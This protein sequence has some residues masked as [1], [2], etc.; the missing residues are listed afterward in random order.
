MVVRVF[1]TCFLALLL[2]LQVTAW[3]AFLQ[4]KE[5]SWERF[6]AGRLEA[7]VDENQVQ[8]LRIPRSWEDDRHPHF[9]HLEQGEVRYFGRQASGVDVFQQNFTHAK[10]SHYC[11]PSLDDS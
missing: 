3:W 6:I 8:V 9:Q 1:Y 10:N 5:A 2:L 4:F 7:G 11:H